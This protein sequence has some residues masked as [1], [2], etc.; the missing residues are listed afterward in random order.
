[1]GA[2]TDSDRDEVRF[3]HIFPCSRNNAESFLDITSS[4][5]SSKSRLRPYPI[6][7]RINTS[8][9]IW[10]KSVK[11]SC[12]QVEA[13]RGPVFKIIRS[14]DFLAQVHF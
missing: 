11:C 2:T 1:V 5:L 13:L 12:S 7:R 14:H 6:F 9:L 8:F 3:E 10:P 4:S